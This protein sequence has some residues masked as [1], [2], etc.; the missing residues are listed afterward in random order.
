LAD[1]KRL[2]GLFGSS[3]SISGDT[4]TVGSRGDDDAGI[5][6]G[7][8]FVFD[9][10]QGGANNWGQVAKLTAS[11]AAAG[12][13]FGFSVS[14]SGDTI[15]VGA[16]SDKDDAGFPSGSAYV[17]DRNQGGANNWGQVAK[18]TASPASMGIQ[19]G[20]SIS[21]SGDTITVGARAGN[22]G[23]AYVFDRNQGGG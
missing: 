11:D 10:N 3:V 8:A 2:T 18:L 6:S 15:T 21:I 19:F 22:P 1:V 20:W 16:I 4:I 13:Q 23:S 14:I 17:F 5:N 12:D 9:R 7:S